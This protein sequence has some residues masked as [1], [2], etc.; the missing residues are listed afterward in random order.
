MA[1][2][3]VGYGTAVIPAVTGGLSGLVSDTNLVAGWQSDLFDNTTTL[4]VDVLIGGSVTCGTTPTTSTYI[5]VYVWAEIA[6]GGPVR[7]DSFGTAAATRSVTTDGTSANFLRLAAGMQVDSS[8]SIRAYWFGPVSVAQL[9]GGTLPSK[10]GFWI[11]HNSG[12]NLNGG[13]LYYT[14]VIYTVN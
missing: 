8:A 6:P 10:W 2:I 7:P 1:N 4:A 3:Q 9:F 12:V 13:N 11:V 14:P 5:F